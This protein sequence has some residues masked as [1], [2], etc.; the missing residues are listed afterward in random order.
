[1]PFARYGSMAQAESTLASALYL[2]VSYEAELV[3]SKDAPL[4]PGKASGGGVEFMRPWT[5]KVY[6]VPPEQ[7]IG[8]SI[9]TK[10]ELR[11]GKP[12]LVRLP[13]INFEKMAREL[14]F[15][16]IFSADETVGGRYS[17][18]TDF[19]MVPAAL[20]DIDVKRFVQRASWMQRQCHCRRR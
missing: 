14:G 18:L 7:V 19:G 12:V 6:G 11:D 16:R 1:M 8:S 9:K 3:E 10:F 2:N 5:E 13:E 17:A 20:L 15:R 4:V